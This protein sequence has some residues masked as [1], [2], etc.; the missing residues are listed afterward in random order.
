VLSLTGCSQ[1]K[2]TREDGLK[3]SDS[4]RMSLCQR[5]RDRTNVNCYHPTSSN[6]QMMCNMDNG[7]AARSMTALECEQKYKIRAYSK[8]AW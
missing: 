4:E 2:Y 7:D 3:M 5:L 6:Q 1:F 8:P